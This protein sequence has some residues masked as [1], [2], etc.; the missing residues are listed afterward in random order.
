MRPTS[1]N[2][3]AEHVRQPG[4]AA[5]FLRLLFFLPYVA[6]YTTLG[7]ASAS[8]RCNPVTRAHTAHDLILSRLL[9]ADSPAVESSEMWKPLGVLVPAVFVLGATQQSL[10]N[11]STRS[12]DDVPVD[13]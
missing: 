9:T 1:P 4:P 3:Q 2:G 7:P 6:Y 10:R 13:F 8:E 5:T 11:D 12:L